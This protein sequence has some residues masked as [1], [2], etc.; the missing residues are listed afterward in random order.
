LASDHSSIEY[1]LEELRAE[2]AAL[3]NLPALSLEFTIWLSKLFALVEAGFGINSDEMRQLRA[4]SPEL[5]SEFYDSVADR[6]GAVALSEK[7]KSHLLTKLNK[8][9]AETIFMRRLYEYDDLIA[10]MI[11]GLRTER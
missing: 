7:G 9:V 8:D 5:P 2:I 4:I 1:K 10:A 6:L 11:H 3:R